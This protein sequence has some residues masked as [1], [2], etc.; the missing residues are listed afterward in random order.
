MP[1]SEIYSSYSNMPLNSLWFLW[2]RNLARMN[3][4][5]A[6]MSDE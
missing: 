6:L 3:F 1:F 2:K 4:T 5:Y